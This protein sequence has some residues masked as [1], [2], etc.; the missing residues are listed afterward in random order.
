VTRRADGM[1]VL[2]LRVGTRRV[3]LDARDVVEVVPGVPLRPAP[4]APA[5]IAGLLDHRDGVAPVVDLTLLLTGVAAAP[6]LSTRLVLVRREDGGLIALRAEGATA[7]SRVDAAPAADGTLALDDG[8]SAELVR[9]TE[10]V[11]A[12]LRAGAP[13]LPQA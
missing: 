10:L 5:A 6:L 1:L 2:L 13:P 9:W 11:P 8:G 4:G 3:A 12:A 7:V